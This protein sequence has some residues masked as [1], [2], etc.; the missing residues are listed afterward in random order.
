[1]WLRVQPPVSNTEF[2]SDKLE[3][4]SERNLEKTND[5]AKIQAARIDRNNN[6]QL[7]FYSIINNRG[8]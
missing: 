3:T 2:F 8:E 6:F 4:L 5:V 7:K 1:M